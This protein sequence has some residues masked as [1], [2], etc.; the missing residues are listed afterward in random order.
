MDKEFIESTLATSGYTYEVKGNSIVVKSD[1]NR[2]DLLN[3]FAALFDGGRYIPN[4]SYS[5]VGHT[6][7]DKFRI[8]VKPVKAG[9]SGAGAAATALGESAQ[10][11]YCAAKWYV[12]GDYSSDG[13]RKA[14]KYVD[15]DASIEDIINKLPGGWR[16]SCVATAESLYNRYRNKKYIFHRGSGLVGSIENEFTRLNR[17]FKKFSNVNKWTPADIWMVEANH[18][19]SIGGYDGFLEFNSYL[20]REANDHKLVGVS[21]KLTKQA[22]VKE[23]NFSKDRSTYKFTG[24]T[25]GKRGFYD[26]KDVY[27]MY[28]GGE[29]QFRGFPTWQGEIKGKFANHGKIS[30]GPIKEILSWYH[31]TAHIP[32]QR[33]VDARVSK[34]DPSFYQD[35]YATY[36]ST[37]RQ[38]RQKPDTFKVFYDNVSK[39]DKNWQTSKYFGTLFIDTAY[40]AGVLDDIVSD[41]MNYA[42]SQ[43]R[44]SAPFI[45][46]S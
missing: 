44:L 16:D 41:I 10:C 34:K 6:Q 35:F 22:S 26:S 19:P 29:I 36:E 28:D 38:M 39:K 25:T 14:A 31:E 21:L 4:S 15:V 12:N 37:M 42:A 2:I 23:I 3:K 18:S 33:N 24:F 11:L 9:G 5:S 40:S 8:I 46:V 17:E 13:L 1:E 32:S 45:K 7:V 27:M 43:S 20:L 30:G